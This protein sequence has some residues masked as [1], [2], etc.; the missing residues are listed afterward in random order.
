MS[1]LRHYLE[2]PFLRRLYEEIRDAGPVRS[3]SLDITSKCNLRCSGC[4]Y[5]AEGMDRHSD[6]RNE[7]AFDEFLDR[8]AERGTNFVTV[9]GGEPAL[10]PERLRKIYARFKMSV[11]SNGLIPIPRQGLEELPIG[12]ALW[13]NA[14]TDA[15]LRGDGRRDFFAL[16]RENYRNDERAF[17]YYTVAPGHAQEVEEVV[18]QCLANGNRLLFNYYSDVERLG[19]ELDYRQGFE[20]VRTEIDR[21]AARYPDRIFTTPYF[22]RVVTS[23]RLFDQAWGYDVCTNVSSN[24]P[25]NEARLANGNPYNRHFRAYNA[26]FKTTRR[27]CTGVSRDCRSCFDT[28]EHFSWIMIHMKKHLGSRE[29]F[30][31]WLTTMYVFYLVNRLVDFERGIEN[32][33]EIQRRQQLPAAAPLQQPGRHNPGPKP[34]SRSLRPRS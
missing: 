14:G 2:D 34:D 16:A 11:A 19:G 26:D 23:G 4:Y 29:D 9:V 5:F 18:E 27:C 30:T 15:R 21:M 3:I 33:G 31:H 25:I 12:V 1:R 24:A 6:H 17:W 22:N 28:W 8:E 7:A 20:A 10:E 32:L 13:G